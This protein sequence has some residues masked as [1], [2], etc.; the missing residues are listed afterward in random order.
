VRDEQL[1]AECERLLA[2]LPP[3][4]T[5]DWDIRDV[6]DQVA[7][8]RNRQIV[9]VEVDLPAG[10][11]CG[12][13]FPSSDGFD[14]IVRPTGASL[15]GDVAELHELMHILAGDEPVA[16]TEDSAP[17]VTRDTVRVLR[18]LMP[19]LPVSMFDGLLG[20]GPYDT[21]AE[22]R[23]EMGAT[24]AAGRLLARRP[25]QRGTRRSPAQDR[26]LAGF[27]LSDRPTTRQ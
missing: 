21:H 27:G 2:Q 1:R 14:L 16:V 4:D 15:R 25:Y 19:D 6:A 26:L 7:R 13:W 10:L 20:R 23:A 18:A 12:V 5:P 3:P 24:I 22:L 11:L 9:R 17:R 8:I